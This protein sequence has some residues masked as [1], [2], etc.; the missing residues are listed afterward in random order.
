MKCFIGRT[1]ENI[2][3]LHELAEGDL[4]VVCAI[5]SIKFIVRMEEK[6]VVGTINYAHLFLY[7][8]SFTFNFMWFSYMCSVKFYRLFNSFTSSILFV[9]DVERNKVY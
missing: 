1:F 7:G 3:T 6:N 8:T 4:K 2:V 9:I 5:C